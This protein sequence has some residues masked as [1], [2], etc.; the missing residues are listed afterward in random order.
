MT[1]ERAKELLPIIQAFAEGKT[2]ECNHYIDNIWVSVSNPSWVE[3]CHYR[4]KPEPV[5]GWICIV[6]SNASRTGYV[7]S[8]IFASE[9]AAKAHA[10]QAKTFHKIVKIRLDNTDEDLFLS[11]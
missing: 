9:H 11:A 8:S 6:K 10:E 5:Y 7:N 2:I 3:G 1:P 4:I